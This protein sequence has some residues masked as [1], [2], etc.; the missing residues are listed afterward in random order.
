MYFLL[1]LL[2]PSCAQLSHQYQQLC[3]LERK[4]SSPVVERHWQLCGPLTI[5]L[6]RCLVFNVLSKTW[7]MFLHLISQSWA[8]QCLLV[9]SVYANIP[10]PPVFLTVLGKPKT[11]VLYLY[12]TCI[13]WNFEVLL[14]SDRTMPTYAVCLVVLQDIFIEF[15][16]V[17]VL[18]RRPSSEPLISCRGQRFWRRPM[19]QNV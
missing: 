1:T 11:I 16:E 3:C 15:N 12:T 14:S 9:V 17:N 2:F 4:P 5:L 19:G 18:A 7:M 6:F 10:L 13:Y 8:I